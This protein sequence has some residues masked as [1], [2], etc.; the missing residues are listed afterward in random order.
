MANSQIA[1]LHAGNLANTGYVMVKTLRKFGLNADLLMEKYPHVT[2]DPKSFDKDLS[3]SYPEWIH[4]WDNKDRGWKSQI[5]KTMKP[6]D[7]IHAHVELPIFALF[8]RKPF[9]AQSH[10]SD[11]RELAFQN[12]S[13]TSVLNIKDFKNS[14]KGILLRRAYHKAK[15]LIYGSPDQLRFIEKLK[16]ANSIFLPLPCDHTIFTQEDEKEESLKDKLYHLP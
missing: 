1:A 9:I 10:G 8:A 3:N 16:L 4:F 5:I 15:A 13:G 7:L 6:Y 2:S 12:I 14:I 11:L